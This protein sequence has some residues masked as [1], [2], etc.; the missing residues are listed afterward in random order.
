[1]DAKKSCGRVSGSLPSRAPSRLRLLSLSCVGLVL[2]VSCGGNPQPTSDDELWAV[3]AAQ[4]VCDRWAQVY[5]ETVDGESDASTHVEIMNEAVA[6]AESA[7]STDSRYSRLVP[8]VRDV[9][10]ALEFG[11]PA[12]RQE[13]ALLLQNMNGAC[14]EIIE[15]RSC[16]DTASIAECRIFGAEG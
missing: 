14:Q 2:L 1:M 12:D 8:I 15:E 5:V 13:A 10:D 9:A 16:I 7:A 3:S 11:F 6:F 4:I